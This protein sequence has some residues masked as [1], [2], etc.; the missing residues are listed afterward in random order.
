MALVQRHRLVHA[1]ATLAGILEDGAK[2]RL[3]GAQTLCSGV[4]LSSRWLLRSQRYTGHKHQ[5]I[6]LEHAVMAQQ[7]D[8]TGLTL[9]A[10]SA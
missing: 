9:L 10:R 4:P 7:H 6:D 5:Q 3:R 1:C 8:L 2:D